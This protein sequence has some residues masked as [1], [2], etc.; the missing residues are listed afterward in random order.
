MKKKIL[1]ILICGVIVLGVTGCGNK[2]EN[3]VP[4]GNNTQ[5]VKKDKEIV[6]TGEIDQTS[7]NE[8]EMT[9]SYEFH[10]NEKDEITTFD[11]ISNMKLLKDT[12]EN[13]KQFNEQTEENVKE[14]YKSMFEF[15]KIEIPDFNVNIKEV[16]STEKKIT[17]TFNYKD[18]IELLAGKDDENVKNYTNFDDFKKYVLKEIVS[19]MSCTYDGK[20]IK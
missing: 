13:R 16:S 6:C 1:M 18:C 4:N 11:L 10:F 5:Q 3:D 15:A 14:S 9:Q 8:M 7:Q 19:D 17:I 20:E 2:K 12:E